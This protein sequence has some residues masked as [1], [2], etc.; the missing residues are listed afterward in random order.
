[1]NECD[2]L[3]QEIIFQARALGIPVSEAIDPHV[4]INSRAVKRFGCCK[5]ENGGQTIEV[6]KR[7]AEGPEEGCRET[8]AHE[9]LHTC[10]GCQNHGELWKEYAR[11]MNLAYGYH[12]SRVSTNEK[13]GVE[14]ERGCKY[15]LR[16]K[17]CG[18]E[19]RRLR[20]SRLI[21]FPERYRCRCGGALERMM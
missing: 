12:I 18:A 15:L 4:R 11:Q 13:M 8:L 21:R 16:C 9:V 7:V 20:A 17:R 6:A 14:E 19:F 1:M 3:L 10:R 5:Y 2:E